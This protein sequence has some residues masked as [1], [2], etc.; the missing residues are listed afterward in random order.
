MPSVRTGLLST[1]PALSLRSCA[2]ARRSSRAERAHSESPV[3]LSGG[4]HTR[5]ARAHSCEGAFH[6]VRRFSHHAFQK[7]CKHADGLYT[8]TW[9]QRGPVS[10]GTQ[11]ASSRGVRAVRGACILCSRTTAHSSRK[12]SSFIRF[13]SYLL[14]FSAWYFRWRC[15]SCRH[16]LGQH[17]SSCITNWN[18][19]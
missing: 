9:S 11:R 13:S 5:A 14:D 17:Y 3:S 10:P 1:P 7:Y 2:H 4:R 18:C 12:W 19:F 16:S 6:L 15:C 8:Y